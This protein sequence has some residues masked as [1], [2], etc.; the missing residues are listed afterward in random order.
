[1]TDGLRDVNLKN[2]LLEYRQSW[3][4]AAGCNPVSQR[5]SRFE[6]YMLHHILGRSSNGISADCKSAAP[7]EHSWFE[8]KAAHQIQ[9][10]YR[11]SLANFQR[12]K[13]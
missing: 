9:K 13:I 1:M 12:S 7:T 10:A 4:A 5:D 6:S 8:S 3:R 2:E 11:G